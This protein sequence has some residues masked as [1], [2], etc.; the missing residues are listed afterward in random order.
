MKDM[1]FVQSGGASDMGFMT[2]NHL[3]LSYR[4]TQ[5]PIRDSSHK[6]SVSQVLFDSLISIDFVMCQTGLQ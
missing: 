3:Q 4:F 1:W 6:A 5:L 2:S